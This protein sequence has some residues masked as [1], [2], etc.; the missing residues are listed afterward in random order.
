ME[1]IA[2]PLI[3]FVYSSYNGDNWVPIV[4]NESSLPR[5]LAQ[6]RP[7]PKA[8]EGLPPMLFQKWKMIWVYG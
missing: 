8:A 6:S 5:P 2:L 4:A 3:V 7:T 1:S